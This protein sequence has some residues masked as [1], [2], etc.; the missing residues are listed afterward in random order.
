VEDDVPVTDILG[1]PVHQPV[2]NT[3]YE[4]PAEL[5]N[6][7][8]GLEVTNYPSYGY[9][10]KPKDDTAFYYWFYKT[11][12]KA[13]NEDLEITE[14]GSYSWLDNRWEFGTVTGKPFEPKD[15]ADWYKC[16]NG[17]LKKGKLY[18]DTNNWSRMSVLQRGK[19]LWYYIGKNKKGELFKG[20]AIV[21]HLPEMKK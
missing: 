13:V 8:D 21:E 20:V 1:E 14:F 4:L 9:A 19:S 5:K 18:S 2:D 17:K 10:V 15:F 12:V 6:V 11:S 16:K 3:N 7:P